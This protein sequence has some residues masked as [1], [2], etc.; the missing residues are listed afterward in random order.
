M[1]SFQTSSLEFS[2]GDDSQNT[3]WQRSRPL[4]IAY[5]D[6]RPDGG[7]PD[8]EVAAVPPASMVRGLDNRG[9]AGELLAPGRGAV[10]HLGRERLHRGADE[11]RCGGGEGRVA[12]AHVGVERGLVALDEAGQDAEVEG[13][14]A[15]ALVGRIDAR[16]DRA[17]ARGRVAGLH[18][19]LERR[20]WY[21]VR[22][23]EVKLG[24]EVRHL[25]YDAL[26]GVVALA[27]HEFT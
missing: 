16:A 22:V 10:P 7:V 11:G 25:L 13:V 19:A 1:P 26:G 9:C 4:P 27:C 8:V 17:E 12:P 23:E 21:E 15:V 3:R 2:S 24:N 6:E 14:E 5:A 20:A 18:D